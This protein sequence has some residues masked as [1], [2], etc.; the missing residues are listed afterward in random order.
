M[1]ADQPMPEGYRL[2]HLGLSWR[3]RPSDELDALRDHIWSGISYQQVNVVRGDYVIEYTKPKALPRLEQPAKIV[4]PVPCKF[5]EKGLL[6]AAMRDVPDLA[7]QKMTVA[8]GHRF[9]LQRAFSLRKAA[10]KRYYTPNITTLFRKIN[11]IGW[12]DRGLDYVS[13]PESLSTLINVC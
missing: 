11:V 4:L 7:G 2:Q 10:S 8:S 9:S 1:H 13:Y 5:Q 6:M 12:S 3:V